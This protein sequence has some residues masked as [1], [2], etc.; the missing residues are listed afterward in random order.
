VH[1]E[2]RPVIPPHVDYRLTELGARTAGH[3]RGLYEWIEQAL[4]D[5]LAARRAYDERRAR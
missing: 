2:V 3:V 5:V 4:P 1:R